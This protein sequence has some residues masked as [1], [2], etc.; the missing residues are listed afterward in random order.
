MPL[1]AGQGEI[2]PEADQDGAGDPVHDLVHPV[3]VEEP[4]REVNGANQWAVMSWGS[5][6]R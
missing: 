1:A 6:A 3:A 4:A 5:I 2:E